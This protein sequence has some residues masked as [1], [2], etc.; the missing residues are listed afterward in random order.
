VLAKS[1][2]RRKAKGNFMRVHRHPMIALI[3]A[4]HPVLSATE[5]A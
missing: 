5:Q 1:N 4:P 2:I 3:G